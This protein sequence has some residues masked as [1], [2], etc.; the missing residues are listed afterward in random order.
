MFFVKFQYRLVSVFLRG[1]MSGRSRQREGCLPD[2]ETGNHDQIRMIRAL[3]RAPRRL[4][5]AGQEVPRGRVRVRGRDTRRLEA[6]R[7]LALPMFL[8]EADSRR[9]E[10]FSERQRSP[11]VLQFA[12]LFAKR[13]ERQPVFLR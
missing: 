10:S 8:H 1:G 7:V 9:I 3:S 6:I 5:R 13:V 2:S 4:G 11:R 12:N